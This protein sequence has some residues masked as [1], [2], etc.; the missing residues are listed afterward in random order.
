MKRV[1]TFLISVIT[2]IAVTI[3]LNA[4]SLSFTLSS[5]NHNYYS[6]NQSVNDNN[7][8]WYVY[9]SSVSFSGMP[10]GTHPGGYEIYF[11][12]YKGDTQVSDSYL[13][14]TYTASGFGKIG[15]SGDSASYKSG[16]GNKGKSYRIKSNSNFYSKSQTVSASWTA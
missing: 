16:Y 14:F 11:R 3:N 7:Y 13:T 6:V 8:S 1:I 10:S 15:V 12:P 9:V 4:A 2:M 5:S